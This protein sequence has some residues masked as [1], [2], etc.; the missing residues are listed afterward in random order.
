MHPTSK[1]N[2]SYL[3]REG[4]WPGFKWS[5]LELR[6]N[7]VLEL[8]S[9][10]RL[11]GVLPDEVASAQTP[12]G[13]AGIAIDTFG[14]IYFSDSKGN[15]VWRIDGCDKGIGAI[16]G[17]GDANG[18]PARLHEPR[19]LLVPH[20]RNAL[21]VADSLNHR[22]QVFDL[23]TLQLLDIWGQPSPGAPPQPDSAPGRFNV[24]FSLA[25][26]ENGNVYV[27]DYGNRRVQ[28][29]NSAGEVVADF[30]ENARTHSSLHDPIEVA[31]WEQG[32]AVG[33]FVLDI[34]AL[35]IFAFDGDGFPILDPYGIGDSHLQQPTG[36][37]VTRNALYIGDNIA[38]RVLR[39]QLN[40]FE[41]VGEA[42]GYEGPVAALTLDHES[43]LWVHAGGSLM[44]VRLDAAGGYRTHGSL[45]TNVP[46]RAQDQ[47]VNWYRLST[48]MSLRDGNAQLELF[49]HTSNDPTDAPPINPS[50]DN[51]FADERWQPIGF[52]GDFDVHDL[53]IGG[54]EAKYL[55]CG[56]L[57]SSEGLGTPVVSQLRVEFDYPS[58]AR[59][60]PAIYH[61]RAK[62]D[63]FLERLL[64]LFESIFDDVEQEIDSLPKLF[65]PRVAPKEF[66]PWLAGVLGLELDDNWSEANQ[67]KIIAEIFRLHGRRGTPA[68]LRE[69]LRIFAQVNA[70]IEEPLVNS[71]WWTLP[72]TTADCCETCSGS[73]GV[74][75]D[76]WQGLENSILGSTTMLAVAQPQ[77]AVVGTSATLDQSSL[78]TVDE[79]GSPL[80][81]DTAYQFSVRVYRAQ[82]RCAEV[83]TR[84]R[85]ILDQEKPAHTTYHLCIV[86]P[87]M[88]VGF[89]SRVGVDT[90]IG[91]QARSLALGS[92][93]VLGEDTLL[94]GAAASRVGI[95]SRL[96]LTTRLT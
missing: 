34:G 12:A 89:Q 82:V 44:P 25:A 18:L 75:S 3:N 10:P 54:P 19:G 43:S 9:L 62:C 1:N 51:P 83:V 13:P 46:I 35:K 28:K 55:W 72:S 21:F 84:I 38:K 94:A 27:V 5:G 40:D 36:L 96:G 33:V 67:R 70:T 57:F 4:R 81:A 59:Y 53:Y 52:A 76:D 79:F 41:F 45:W 30:W 90:V 63:D 20:N 32:G 66:L 93:Q 80:F 47:K 71:A 95:E 15:R 7:G 60:L 58:Y 31:V 16:A 65:D 42:I 68:G 88:R 85:A 77:G 74:A 11:M 49:V 23:N 39:F 61:D 92:D 50:A 86:E 48:M 14:S 22:I 8:A 2:Y 87:R 56:A 37:A 6:D 26:D 73:S 64:S 78:I 17:I 29:F 24:P 69:S 91:G